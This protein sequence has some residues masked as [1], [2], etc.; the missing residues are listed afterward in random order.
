MAQHPLAQGRGRP[1]QT[2]RSP[3][4][5]SRLLAPT[6]QKVA[7]ARTRLD[8]R[9][10]LLRHVEAIRLYAAAHGG[11][12]PASLADIDVPLPD[13]PFTGKPFH[14]AVEG[15]K[16]TLRG[17]PPRGMEKVAGFNVEYRVTI[18]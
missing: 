13:D 4:N 15:K 17:T 9:F 6:R 5:S 14:Y 16:A 18:R 7:R 10:A 3:A 8:Q 11:K 12:L 2:P 1:V